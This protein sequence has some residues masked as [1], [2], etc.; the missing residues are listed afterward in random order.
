MT[1]FLFSQLEG[2]GGEQGQ[3]EIA[4][5]RGAVSKFGVGS[6]FQKRMFLECKDNFHI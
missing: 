4:W 3:G 5:G 1:R 2:C 6:F